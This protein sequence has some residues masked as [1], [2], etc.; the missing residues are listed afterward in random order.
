MCASAENESN[1]KSWKT[2]LIPLKSTTF[3]NCN[4]SYLDF[5]IIFSVIIYNKA[6]ITFLGFTLITEH[7]VSYI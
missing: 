3:C 5:N 6:L 7:F 1:A 2:L 4:I